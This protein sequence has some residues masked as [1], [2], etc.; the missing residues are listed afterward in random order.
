MNFNSF[1]PRNQSRVI[2]F[3]VLGNHLI[4]WLD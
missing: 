4:E 3:E 1:Y 2:V